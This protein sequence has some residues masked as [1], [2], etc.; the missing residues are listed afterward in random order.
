MDTQDTKASRPSPNLGI[1][2]YKDSSWKTRH[3]R[4]RRLRTMRAEAG[5]TQAALAKLLGVNE[6]HIARLELRGAKQMRSQRLIQQAEDL[7]RRM[8]RGKTGGS[9]SPEAKHASLPLFP[10]GNNVLALAAATASATTNTTKAYAHAEPMSTILYVDPP[11]DSEDAHDFRPLVLRERALI[12]R[13]ANRVGGDSAAL[14]LDSS[15]RIAVQ[16]DDAKKRTVVVLRTGNFQTGY[17]IR[18]GVA[19]R[20]T[21]GPRADAY[22]YE[23]GLDVGLS[24]AIRSTPIDMGV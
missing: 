10:G 11:H 19:K 16:E 24:R 20:T 5:L 18:V 13:I 7:L 17:Q 1:P 2:H 14:A 12:Q 21:Y 22:A 3:P 15:A 6:K 23:T 8:L 9:G 4:G